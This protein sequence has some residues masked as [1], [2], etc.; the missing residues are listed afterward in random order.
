MKPASIDD[1]KA[2]VREKSQLVHRVAET[3]DGK[4]LLD[5]L[6]QTFERRS[7]FDDSTNKMAYNL[8]QRDV[9]Q[10]L[11]ELAENMNNE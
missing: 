7:L 3:H 8:G 4:A 9:V 5:M 6:E 10:Y 2:A 1:W 11:R